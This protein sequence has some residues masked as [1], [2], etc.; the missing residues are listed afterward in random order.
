MFSLFPD[1]AIAAP[2]WYASLAIGVGIGTIGTLIGAGGGFLLMPVLVMAYPHTPPAVLAAISLA[3]VFANAGSGSFAYA[4]MGRIDYKA[5]LWFAAAGIPGSIAGAIVTSWLDRRLFDPLLG[6]MLVLVASLLMLRPTPPARAS[7]GA[8]H[9][10]LVES[11]G[12]VHRYDPRLGLGML[13]SVFVGFA[14]SLLGIGGG[15]LHVPL[16]VF[17]LG[18]PVHVAT[19]TSHFVLAI[20]ALTGTAT[21]AVDGTLRPG[22]AFAL[23]L[24]A[25]V[26]AG[27]PLG[28]RLSGRLSGPWIMRGLAIALALA[29][30]RLLLSR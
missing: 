16:M 13:L 5:G 30:L 14:S 6:G 9:R 4:R 28:A 1:L 11:D 10:T 2:P 29:G 3:V 18:F 23:P 15:I 22:L 26:L 20:V 7:S 21:H 8:G 27:A 12:T 25:G 24:A 17:A 19:A